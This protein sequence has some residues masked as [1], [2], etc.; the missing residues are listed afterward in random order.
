MLHPL[1]HRALELTPAWLVELVSR[2]LLPLGC[3]D[4]AC[5]ST[6]LLVLAPVALLVAAIVGRVVARAAWPSFLWLSILLRVETIVWGRHLRHLG[7][8]FGTNPITWARAQVALWQLLSLEAQHLRDT[9]WARA[10]GLEGDDAYK[11]GLKHVD[12]LASQRRAKATPGGGGMAAMAKDTPVVKDVVLIGG[13]HAHAFV[14]KNFGMHPIPGVKLT[15]VTRDVMT[16]YSG[17][18]PGH[19]A[20]M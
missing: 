9:Y 8:G 7:V 16:P 17:M 14:L 20:G 11:G 4:D 6:S 1:Q 13:G 3:S 15:L 12:T 2:A 19:V 5:L 10:L 18:L